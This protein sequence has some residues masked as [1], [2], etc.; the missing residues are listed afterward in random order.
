MKEYYN[1]FVYDDGKVQN[2]KTGLFLK[3]YRKPDGYEYVR[4]YKDGKFERWYIHRLVATCYLPKVEGKNQVN[5]IN[6]IRYDNRVD[7]LEWVDASENQ[8]HSYTN[9]GTNEH[10]VYNFVFKGELISVVN[11]KQFCNEYELSYTS[12]VKV[13]TGAH[14]NHKGYTKY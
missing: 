14:K 10:K 4:L 12:M 5:H 9:T 13:A 1:Y 6:S 8:K 11:L 2:K 7:N 3:P